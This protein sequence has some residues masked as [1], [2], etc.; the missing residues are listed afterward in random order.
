[1]AI[2]LLRANPKMFNEQIKEVRANPLYKGSKW[3]MMTKA[4]EKMQP[5]PPIKVNPLAVR[6]CKSLN[7]AHLRNAKQDPAEGGAIAKLQDIAGK[8]KTVDAAEHTSIKWTGSALE[9]VLLDLLND[10]ERQAKK[11]P[12]INPLTT[13]LGVSFKPH[14]KCKNVCQTI[15][16]KSIE[17]K[18]ASAETT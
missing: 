4:L 2:N 5:L 15:Y 13:G 7:E 9:L 6:A 3:L 18:Q 16:V 10:Y 12:V 8:D 17:D 11:S 14:K 1:M